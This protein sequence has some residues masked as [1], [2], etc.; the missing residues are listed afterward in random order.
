M[1][2]GL[3]L[4]LAVAL[5]AGCGS[6]HNMN[7]A[8]G[9]DGASAAGGTGGGGGASGRGGAA[10]KSGRGGR[11]DDDSGRGGSGRGGAG[12]TDAGADGPSVP[13]GT[14]SCT[15]GTYCCNPTCGV[16][17]PRGALC[18][19]QICGADASSGF[20]AFGCVAIPALDTGDCRGERPPHFYSCVMSELPAPCVVLNTGNVT[21]TYC[22]P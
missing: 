11:G 18:T 10:G 7:G 1:R 12:V 4:G 2:W 21:N 8:G 13:C 3:I 19:A 16:C 5:G 6:P 15:G 9:S 22:C 14:N 20:D 17:A